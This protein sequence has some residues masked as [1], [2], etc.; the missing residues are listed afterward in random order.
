MPSPKP[1][2]IQTPFSSNTAN[3]QTNTYGTMSIADTPEAQALLGVPIDVDPGV[4]RRTDLA[5]QELENRFNSAFAS[6]IPQHLRM[7]MME[8]QRR[9]IRSQGAAEAQNA[10]YAKKLM[11]M[12]RRKLLLPQIVQTGGS[13]TGTSSGY[14]SQVVQPQP[15]GFWGALG[16]IGGAA[17]SKLP[18]I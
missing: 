15:S 6:G 1:K 10:E 9:Q 16:S 14:N 18:A 5:E 4:G 12:E 13:S 8:N 7:N 17:I 3:T 2:A 11:E